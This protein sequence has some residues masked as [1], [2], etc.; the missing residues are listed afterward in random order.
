MV[1]GALCTSLAGLGRNPA[2]AAG[3]VLAGTGLLGQLAFWIA[4][5]REASGPTP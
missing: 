2:L 1:I 5:R 4:L 3:A